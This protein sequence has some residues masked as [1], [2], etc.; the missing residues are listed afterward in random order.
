MLCASIHVWILNA[1][2]VDEP[3]CWALGASGV[4]ADWRNDG[5]KR[6]SAVVVK[7]VLCWAVQPSP[8]DRNSLLRPPTRISALYVIMC[9]CE[10]ARLKKE[11]CAPSTSP[12]SLF[13]SF[14]F[15]PLESQSQQEVVTQTSG[16]PCSRPPTE[17]L[18]LQAFCE[19][20]C[21][22]ARHHC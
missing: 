15:F 17:H 2:V 21:P 16:V 13:S 4:D 19:Q 1:P 3:L 12:P 20:V 8:R 11:Y 14:F 7:G 10:R 9:A 5:A 6:V 18:Y 22:P